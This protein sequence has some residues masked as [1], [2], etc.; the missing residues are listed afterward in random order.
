MKHI[1]RCFPVQDKRAGSRRVVI[2]DEPEWWTNTI[3]TPQ[4]QGTV[5]IIEFS[6]YKVLFYSTSPLILPMTLWINETRNHYPYFLDKKIR[7]S[8]STTEESQLGKREQWILKVY[9]ISQIFVV[10][11]WLK[12]RITSSDLNTKHQLENE[13][14]ISPPKIFSGQKPSYSIITNSCLGGISPMQL[15]NLTFVMVSKWLTT[16]LN[17]SL[18]LYKAFFHFQ[19]CDWF[20]V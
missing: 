3:N 8:D 15:H 14:L 6:L 5:V 2:A 9:Q 18:H 20:L 1:V 13:N 11:V 12:D 17:T 4:T 10:K 7:E 16:W 19:P